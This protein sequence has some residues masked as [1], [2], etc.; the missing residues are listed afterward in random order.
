MKDK[1]ALA[2]IVGEAWAKRMVDKMRSE[3]TTVGGDWPGRREDVAILVEPLSDKADERR[4]LTRIIMANA[5]R[6]WRVLIAAT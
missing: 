5:K 2:V 6:A 3:G 4:A 1:K